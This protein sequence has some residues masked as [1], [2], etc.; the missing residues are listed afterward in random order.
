MKKYLPNL[1]ELIKLSLPIILGNLGVMLVGVGDVYV[2]AKY[3]TD[4]LASIS[5]ASSILFTI[6]VFGLGILAGISPLLSNYRGERRNVKKYFLPTIYFALTLALIIVIISLMCIPLVD[7]M[8]FEAK[9]IPDIKQYMAICSF[10]TIAVFLFVGLKE[11]LQAFEIVLL[12]NVINFFGVA[13]N[14]FL[15]FIFVFGLLGAPEMGCIGIAWA[16]LISRATLAL[17]L[18]AIC[19]I[20][21]RIIKFNDNKYYTQLLK[22]GCPIALAMFFECMAFNIITLFIGRISGLYAAAQ[23][24]L[25]SMVNL[26]FMFPLSISNAIAVKVGYSNGAKDY[27]E[28]K[29][30]I[31]SGASLCVGLMVICAIFYFSIPQQ[32]TELFTNDTALIAACVPV[33]QLIGIFQIFDGLQIALGG[34]FKGMKFTKIV[35]AGDFVAYWILGIPLGYYCAFVRQMHLYGFWIGITTA[36][37]L[38]GTSFLILMIIYLKKLNNTAKI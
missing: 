13:L 33:L 15:N 7:K 26:T 28:L 37:A 35:M 22:I 27:T 10:S 24:I 32:L 23:N 38:L 31:V 14:I 8:G 29:K 34:A 4:A 5:I 6:F 16:T 20:K 25:I 2:A 17:I 36:I 30:Y 9:L 1:I 21:I 11:Y 3:S 18:L 12:P 19:V